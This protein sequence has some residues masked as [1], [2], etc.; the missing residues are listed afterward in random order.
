MTLASR[1]LF[2]ALALLAGCAMTDEQRAQLDPATTEVAPGQGLLAARVLISI[3]A[4]PLKSGYAILTLSRPD[5][6]RLSIR[7]KTTGRAEAA[8]FLEPLPPGRYELHE[9]GD[10]QVWAPL[11]SLSGSFE[12]A[13]GRVTDLGALVV[14]FSSIA[15]RPGMFVSEVGRFVAAQASAP[16][17]TA[18][19]L[20]SLPE[21]IRQPLLE[22]E[23]LRPS[24]AED[25]HVNGAALAYAKARAGIHSR[26]AL[27]PGEPI[28][29]GRA[30]GQVGVWHPGTEALY[31][32][33]TGRT[34]NVRSVA[35]ARDGSLLAGMEEGVLMA[36][37]G[38]AWRTLPPPS[39]NA[40]IAFI[41]QADSG[42]YL[43]LAVGHRAARLLSQ[44][45]LDAGWKLEREFPMGHH[46]AA[47]AA[48][49]GGRLVVIVRDRSEGLP[50]IHVL[51]LRT[52][53][54]TSASPPAD[55]A[56]QVL[57]DG[58]LAATTREYMRGLRNFASR[59]FGQTWEALQTD[60][61]GAA[62]FFDARTVYLLWTEKPA[63]MQETVATTTWIERSRDG[64]RSWESVGSLVRPFISGFS[65]GATGVYAL[66]KPGWFLSSSATGEL[67]VS[68][69]EGSTWQPARV[70]VPR[71]R[72]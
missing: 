20:G 68:P 10:G 64:G 67:E 45:G 3:R 5:G 42:E 63:F 24:I 9:L 57:R 16:E 61:E 17:D 62:V 37:R 47:N 60:K 59:D 33:D 39:G 66:P 6:S 22:R 13:T 36:F 12:V 19:L 51:D 38:G 28:A 21:H 31:A 72:R 11:K 43:V 40:A 26:S 46:D 15:R 55:G 32:L 52:R 53:E 65:L 23:P 30:L 2:A 70:L 18:A 49:G 69:D 41:G 71:E 7:S 34:L 25:P 54:W 4:S 27:V 8:V 48:L 35:F 29:F 56:L 14:V 1:S 58:T 44:E 50:A